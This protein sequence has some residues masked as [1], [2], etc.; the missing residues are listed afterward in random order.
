[1]SNFEIRKAEIEDANEIGEL[2]CTLANKFITPEFSSQA[3]E[4][5][6]AL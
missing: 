1:M 6:P 2:I 5:V 3:R 4:Q